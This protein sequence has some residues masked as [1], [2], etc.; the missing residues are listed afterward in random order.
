MDRV[1]LIGLDGVPP[2]LLFGPW[3]ADLPVIDE[4]CRTGAHGIL[5]SCL[6]PITV[7]AWSCMLSSQDPGQLGIYGFRNRADHGYTG[8]RMATSRDIRAP[9]VWDLIGRAGGRSVVIGVPG[10]YPPPPI[11]GLVVSDFLAPGRDA[12][13]THPSP[14]RTRVLDLAP[15]YRFDV[16]DFRHRALPS[17]VADVTAMTRERFRLARALAAEPWDF[18]ALHEIGTD[19]LHHRLWPPS[20]TESNEITS[21]LLGYYKVLDYE[22]GLLLS[23]LPPDTAV[24]IASDHGA[25][26]MRGGVRVNQ[27]LVDQG[28]LRL[29]PGTP[30]GTVTPDAIDWD[31]TV[32]W[33]EGGYYARLC[34]NIK[35]REPFGTVP[36][37]AVPALLDELRDGLS[38]IRDSDGERL[39]TTARTPAEVYRAQHGVPPDLLVLF[40]DLA[41]R[42]IGTLAEGG[43]FTTDN[44]LGTDIAN[45]SMDGVVVIHG[46]NAQVPPNGA[47][48]YDIAPTILDLLGVP[49]PPSMVG[50]SLIERRSS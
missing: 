12:A 33:G 40:D 16:T 41:C 39:Q 22:L 24:I 5:W 9:R 38:E 3:R 34:L 37:S 32:A 27:W 47:D 4:L 25:R 19:R 8:L 50:R 11:D 15:D 23:V 29:L 7:P 26:R 46:G 31:Q 13:F 48:I 36:E 14:A 43:V 17:L 21:L 10:T 42:S 35:G 1:A 20:F 30:A 28:Y 18:F 6:P 44:D 45:H 2:A 49:I